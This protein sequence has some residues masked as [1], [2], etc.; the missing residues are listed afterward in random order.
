MLD[1]DSKRGIIIQNYKNV[2]R[3]C[4]SRL[5]DEEDACDVTQD[6]FVLLLQKKD[7]LTEQNLLS[8]LLSA[9][10]KRVKEKLRQQSRDRNT[11]EAFSARFHEETALAEL[12]DCL[13]IT[14]EA[15]EQKRAE[16]IASL[17]PAE[18]QLFRLVFDEK[19]KYR[20]IAELLHSNREAIAMRVMRLRKKIIQIVEQLQ[21]S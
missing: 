9:A 6:V 14:D 5:Q 13:L 11:M 2:Y 12:E 7:R 4:L 19:L 10:D 21:L 15:I 3:Y 20:A 8:W 1:E 17:R 16:I 18:Q